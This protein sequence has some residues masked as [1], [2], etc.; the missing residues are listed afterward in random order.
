MRKPTKGPI[1]VWDAGVDCDCVTDPSISHEPFPQLS[2]KS[3][4][5]KQGLDLFIS[6]V[7]LHQ[8]ASSYSSCTQHVAPFIRFP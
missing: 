3:S 6:D 8:N 5:N 1:S 7:F 2:D 4:E